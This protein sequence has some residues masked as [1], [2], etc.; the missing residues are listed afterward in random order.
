MQKDPQ[1]MEV[2]TQDV[3]SRFID[4]ALLGAELPKFRES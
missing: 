4:N 3:L 1:L 2:P